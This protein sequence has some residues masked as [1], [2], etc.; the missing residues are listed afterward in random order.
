M[1]IQQKYKVFLYARRSS[2]ESSDKQAQSIEDQ[3]NNLKPV[4]DRFGFKIVEIIEESKSSKQ[5]YIRAKFTQM[6]ERIEKGE[7]DGILTWHI[8]RL[9]RNPVDSGTLGWMLQKGVIKVIRTMEREYLPEDNVLLF[10]VE[11]AMANQYIRDLAVVS[12][13]GMQSKADKGWLPS[14]APLGYY[15][16]TLKQEIY[17][18]K[19]RWDMVRKMWDMV[20]TCNYT[21]SQI[22]EMADTEWG[23]RTPKFKR[24]G[25]K[26]VALSSMYRIFTNEFYTGTFSWSGDIYKGNHKPMISVDEYDKV[27][28][29]LGREGKP[30]QQVHDSSYTGIV[31]C[32]ECGAMCTCSVKKKIIKTTGELK[33]YVYYNCTKKKKDETLKR[34]VCSQRPVTLDKF[35]EQVDLELE[36]YTIHPKFQEWAL[37]IINRHNNTEIRERTSIY[38]SQQK[39]YNEIQKQLDTLTRMRYRDLIDD[40]E[41]IKERDELNGKLKKL[42]T[43]LDSTESRAKK[44]LELTEQTFNFARYARKEYINGDIQKKREIFSALGQNYVLKDEKVIIEANEWLLPIEKAYPALKAEFNRLELEKNLGISS[45][46]EHFEPLIHTWGAVVEDVRTVYEQRNEVTIYLP[47]FICISGVAKS[48]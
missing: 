6:L 3:I 39:T 36:R 27:Q 40:E 43:L 45:R 38:E 29:I 48:C 33:T 35:E 42:K 19:E 2:D 16:D 18:D 30:R 11:G 15:N 14:R 37:E 13:R 23:F 10:S 5:P 26:A 12:R 28:V 8:N 41:F 17:P 34:S 46:N 7:A 20:L 22:Q 4:A 31:R 24:S 25:D 1:K 32:G 44:W 21:V 9:S 47:Q